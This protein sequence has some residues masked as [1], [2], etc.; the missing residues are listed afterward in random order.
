MLLHVH[1]QDQIQMKY[2][3]NICFPF[4]YVFHILI[5]V[6]IVARNREV[7]QYVHVGIAVPQT[8]KA[9]VTPN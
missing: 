4:S 8:K 7:I 3:N 1:V 2:M 6:S 9:N 5:L